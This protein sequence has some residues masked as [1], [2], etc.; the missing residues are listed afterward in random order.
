MRALRIAWVGT[1]EPDFG[2]NKRIAEF[3]EVMG[4]DV[5]VVRVSLWPSDRLA[6]FR[7]GRLV[8][9]LKAVARYLQLIVKL[10]F[11]PAPDVYLV[12]YPGW[13]DVPP[14]KVISLLK[15]RPLVFDPFISLHDT[16]VDDRGLVDR[17]TFMARFSR[18]IDRVSIRRSDKVLADTGPHA[19]KFAEI[20]DVGRDHFALLP[21]GAD[22]S[23]FVADPGAGPGDG[24]VLFYGTYVP[25]QG[26]STILNAAA[27]VQ[28][29]ASFVMI[30]EGQERVK[31]IDMAKSLE[32]SNVRFMEAVDQQELVNWIGAADLCLGVFGTSGKADRV[33]PHK[34]YESLSV[35]R[36]VLT[37]SSSGVTETLGRVVATSPPGDPLSLAREIDRLLG[38]P[39]SRAQLAS[40]GN[41]AY[42]E[43][44][45]TVALSAILEKELMETV[46]AWTR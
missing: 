6:A 4:A 2:R 11:E 37:R 17:T 40:R 20:A 33:V 29:N 26:V 24:L 16:A 5:R 18:W 9:A 38:D 30:G 45:S 27:L 12:S 42:R 7:S 34:V 36:A 46:N 41:A 39:E 32:V 43:A 35:G 13:F 22:D 1:F 21:L 44:F 19:L 15:R 3:L 25:L 14:V 28:S 31:A 8:L 23:V 10:I